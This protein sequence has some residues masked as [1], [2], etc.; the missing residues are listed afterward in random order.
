M[1]YVLSTSCCP[2]MEQELV[3]SMF[4]S[5]IAVWSKRCA[6]KWD[7]RPDVSVGGNRTPRG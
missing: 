5:G 6:Y 4:Y 7:R 3:A 2:V 1:R